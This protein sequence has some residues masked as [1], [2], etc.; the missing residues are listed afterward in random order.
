MAFYMLKANYSAD[1]V[2]AMISEPQDR[3][4]AARKAI[5]AL[6]GTLHSFFFALGDSDIVA[7]IE[8]PDDTA[9][10]AGSMLVGASG[11]ITNVSTTKLLTMAQAKEAMAKAGAAV[12]AFTSPTG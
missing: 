8:A 11:S 7:I 10:A 2:K 3:E 6:G 9:M 12:A 5:E 4:A 1:A